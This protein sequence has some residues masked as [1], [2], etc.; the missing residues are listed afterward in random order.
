MRH[1]LFPTFLLL[2]LALS[3]SAC[4]SS[5]PQAK[6]TTV[7]DPNDV[8]SAPDDDTSSARDRP[9][10]TPAIELARATLLAARASA[11]TQATALATPPPI[12]DPFELLAIPTDQRSSKDLVLVAVGD[13]SQ[14]TKQWVDA[15]MRLKTDAFA[16]TQHLLDSGDLVFMNLENPISELEP[17]AKKTYAF[18]SH[19]ERLGWYFDVGFNLFSLA[20]NHIADADQPGIDDTI[21]HLEKYSTERDI[22]AWWAGAGSSVEEAEQATIFTPP[23]KDIRIAFFSTGFSKGQNVSKF[24][25]ESLTERIAKIDAE[26]DLVIVSVHAGKEYIHIPEADLTSRYRAWVDA[27]ADLVIGHHP[28]VIRPIEIYK[29]RP[30]LHS[31]GNYVFASRTVRHRKMKARMYGLMPRVVIQDGKIT[32]VEI[33]PTWVNNSNGWTLPSGESMPNSNFV[34][35]IIEGPFADAFFEDFYAWTEASGATF[36][37]RHEDVGRYLISPPAVAMTQR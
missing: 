3:S 35:Q 22:P 30:I 17:T 13:V 23:G 29:E 25:S 10:L 26:V 18:T 31:L 2:L 8:P 24:W 9:A 5:T 28:H 14:P 32:A 34:P 19:P 27:G 21:A 37:E 15:T 12:T 36:P 7:A 4:K 11:D 33:T 16:P 20:N 6:T 1:A